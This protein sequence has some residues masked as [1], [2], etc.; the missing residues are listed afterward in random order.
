MALSGKG[1]E[2]F[3]HD[4][5]SG[6]LLY[7][8]NAGRGYV[9]SCCDVPSVLVFVKGAIR[10]RRSA[11]TFIPVGLPRIAMFQGIIV[12]YAGWTRLDVGVRELECV[13]GQCH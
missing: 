3:R 5:P 9:E 6:R 12:N 10:W 4:F 2:G 11:G 1:L 8:V 13:D 7:A